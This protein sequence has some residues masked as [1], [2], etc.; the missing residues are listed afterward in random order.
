MALWIQA[1]LWGA[2]VG[3]ALLIG[4]YLGYYLKLS[5]RVVAGIM[6]FGSGALL[7]ALSCSLL[8]EASSM[9]GIPW[10]IIG[11]LSGVGVYSAANYLLSRAGAKHRK[12]SNMENDPQMEHTFNNS[13]AIAAGA[14]IDGIPEAM[15]I[16]LSMAVGGTVSIVMV[17]A[18]FISNLPEGL[19]SSVGMKNC[20]KRFRYPLIIFGSIC[21]LCA[22]SSLLGYTIVQNARPETIGI[23][24]AIAAGAILAMI[25]DTMIP[26]AFSKTHNWAGLITA[27]G[28]M[29]IFALDKI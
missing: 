13:K 11:F 4:A 1:T 27:I 2:F 28:F 12:R 24:L 29:M 22:I 5:Q 17:T 20:G 10:T 26:E 6:A 3:L 23:T 7:A 18:I 8:E 16:G 21:L 19:S 14:L 25:V 15:V 9:G